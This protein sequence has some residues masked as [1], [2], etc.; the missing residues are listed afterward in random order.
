MISIGRPSGRGYCTEK[1]PAQDATE[2]PSITT[3]SDLTRPR[4]RLRLARQDCA[5]DSA[6]KEGASVEGGLRHGQPIE[7]AGQSQRLPIAQLK[8]SAVGFHPTPRFEFRHTTFASVI[9]EV[10]HM[11]HGPHGRSDAD[12]QKPEDRRYPKSGRFREMDKTLHLST[13][14]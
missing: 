3:A 5:L 4:H 8:S 9:V 6:T 13:T 14:A 2:P 12:A 7:H 11:N 1:E 10:I